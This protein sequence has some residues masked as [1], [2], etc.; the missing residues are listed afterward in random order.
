MFLYILSIIESAILA[1]I[2]YIV[3]VKYPL[4]CV[5]NT[6]C[7]YYSHVTR[8]INH[9]FCIHYSAKLLTHRRTC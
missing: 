5:G 2:V 1:A 6:L 4:F 9:S 8:P 3:A 7:I